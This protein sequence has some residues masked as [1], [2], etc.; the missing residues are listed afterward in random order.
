MIFI[1]GY[2][3]EIIAGKIGPFD[4]FQAVLVVFSGLM[5]IPILMIPACLFF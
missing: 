4:V 5:I 3:N 2:I 1:Q